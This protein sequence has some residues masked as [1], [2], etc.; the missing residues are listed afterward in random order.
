VQELKQLKG[1]LTPYESLRQ[2]LQSTREMAELVEHEPDDA[3]SAELEAESSEL[4]RAV[5][6]S[7]CRPCCRARRNEKDARCSR[8]IRE[9]AALSRRTG[10][11]C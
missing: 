9:P 7:S 1:W 8:S 4:V 11:R 3:M 5:E 2:R 6:R 10:P